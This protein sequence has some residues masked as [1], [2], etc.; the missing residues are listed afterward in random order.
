MPLE[1][2]RTKQALQWNNGS[3]TSIPGTFVTEGVR[4]EG[5]TWAM[6]PI[7]PR[8]LSGNCRSVLLFSVGVRIGR[9]IYIY[10]YRIRHKTITVTVQSSLP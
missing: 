4:P 8:C 1:F 7:P 3:R 5:S 9:I 2:D 10:I 6:N